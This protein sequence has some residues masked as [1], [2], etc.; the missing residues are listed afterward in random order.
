M[1]TRQVVSPKKVAGNTILFRESV[2]WLTG[3]VSK[4]G[5]DVAWGGASATALLVRIRNICPQAKTG[6]SPDFGL[7]A[8][9][10]YVASTSKKLIH[11]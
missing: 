8:R 6:P 10:L 4:E 3:L 1:G 2:L 9:A 5:H 7:Y 11:W